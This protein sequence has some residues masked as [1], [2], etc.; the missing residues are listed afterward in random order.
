[1]SSLTVISSGL[2]SPSSSHLLAEQL[3][4]AATTALPGEVSTTW[5]EVRDHA[6]AIADALLAGYPAPEL[7]QAL[8]AVQ[9]ADALIVV[10]P[11]FQGS[12][13]GLFKSFIDLLEPHALT[14]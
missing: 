2:R 13:A 8:T 12:F 7:E 6:H 5:V 14:H 1:M 4:N 3:A 11:T 9:Q 10:T